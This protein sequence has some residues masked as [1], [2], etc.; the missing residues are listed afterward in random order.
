MGHQ[1]SKSFNEPFAPRALRGGAVALAL[2]VAACVALACWW[3][4]LR[5][6]VWDA[7]APFSGGSAMLADLEPPQG[8]DG[9]G[10]GPEAALAAIG[11]DGAAL[12]MGCVVTVATFASMWGWG[13]LAAWRSLH[14]GTWVGGSL[15]TVKSQSTISAS[16]F[17]QIL[18]EQ[19]DPSP[20]SD[21]PSISAVSMR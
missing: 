17:R 14:D 4:T 11:L 6:A 15:C 12:A 3:P 10:P 1:R 21:L 2:A 7:M 8:L 19:R 18:H 9:T 13:E 16:G 5:A 20:Y